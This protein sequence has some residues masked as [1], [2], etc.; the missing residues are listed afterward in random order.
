M[1]AV[2]V[3]QSRSG[4]LPGLSM[5]LGSPAPNQKRTWLD[6]S[7]DSTP[8]SSYTRAVRVTVL[9]TELL[10]C[11]GETSTYVGEP[12][13]M[14]TGARKGIAGAIE[15]AQR[16]TER[17]AANSAVRGP[18]DPIRFQPD[19]TWRFLPLTT[20]ALLA[21]VTVPDGLRRLGLSTPLS[22]GRK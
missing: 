8:S 4:L 17:T 3:E 13:A 21:Q 18:L 12:A 22:E 11:S 16:A 10:P 6:V 9:P 20:L 1:P 14:T 7:V 19:G 5:S 2:P 15:S